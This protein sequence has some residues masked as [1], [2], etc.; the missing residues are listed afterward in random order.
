MLTQNSIRYCYSTI[1]NFKIP[2]SYF[3][4]K[5]TLHAHGTHYRQKFRSGNRVAS[6]LE[7]CRT[8]KTVFLIGEELKSGN[9]LV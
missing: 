8:I 4:Q 3:Q 9:E 2:L 7:G 5:H 1:V 6:Y